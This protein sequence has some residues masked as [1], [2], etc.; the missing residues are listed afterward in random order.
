[1]EVDIKIPEH[2]IVTA[3]DEGVT[4]NRKGLR[5][6]AN[7]G[8]LGE[9]KIPYWAIASVN[10]RKSTVFGGKFELNT[11]SGPQKNGG[12][13]MGFSAYGNNTAIVFRNG[14]NEEMAALKDFVEKKMKE[15]HEAQHSSTVV[16]Q[17]SDADELAKFK[18]L[19]DDGT[20][21]QEEFDAKKKQLLGL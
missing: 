1:M 13:G 8:N 15:A 3:D 19:F 14:K 16:Q 11:I 21:T 18:K 5:N 2:V 12:L 10:Y 9:T 17:T 7:R 6:M 4:I 20:I